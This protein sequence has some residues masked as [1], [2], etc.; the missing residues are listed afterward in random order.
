VSAR[1]GAE[2]KR[3]PAHLDKDER[4]RDDSALRPD[5]RR[6]RHR[7]R[8]HAPQ[9]P[10]STAPRQAGPK[11]P[12]RSR[13]MSAVRVT[14]W[15]AAA[16]ARTLMVQ[17]G[18]GRVVQPR[19]AARPAGGAGGCALAHRSPHRRQCVHS[20]RASRR[21]P[22]FTDTPRDGRQRRCRRPWHRPRSRTLLLQKVRC[23]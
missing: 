3:S 11:I 4:K 10:P 6:W 16:G 19:A 2:G 14:V 1:G 12:E 7:R 21:A 23:A 9:Q 8:L 20:L 5:P 15:W 22:A 17:P 13:I 18:T